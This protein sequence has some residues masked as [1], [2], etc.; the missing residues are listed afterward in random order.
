[1]DQNEIGIIIK[2]W[3]GP[4]PIK[5]NNNFDLPFSISEEIIHRSLEESFMSSWDYD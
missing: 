4:P 2:D 1:M 5:N 3:F